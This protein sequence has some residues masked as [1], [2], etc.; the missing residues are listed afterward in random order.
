MRDAD[1]LPEGAGL[2]LRGHV[3]A[4]TPP[5]TSAAASSARVRGLRSTS[6]ICSVALGAAPPERS[7]PLDCRGAVRTDVAA[8]GPAG[9]GVAAIWG[10]GACGRGIGVIN[11]GGRTLDS[12]TGTFSCGAGRT[13]ASAGS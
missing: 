13:D 9:A 1:A 7:V 8:L 6:M 5:H 10:A 12:V 3:S 2:G 11:E 4:R